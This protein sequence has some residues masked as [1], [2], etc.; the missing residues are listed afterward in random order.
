MPENLGI[1]NVDLQILSILMEN[2]QTPYTEIAKKIFVSGGTIHVRMK[3]L[4]S[5]GVVRGSQVVIDPSKIGY[6]ITAFLGV[7]LEKNSLYDEVA[8]QLR[9]ISEVT[10]LH[11]TTG[12]YAMFI[13]I[14]C[15]DTQHLRD[16]LHDK[17][18]KVSGIQ[19]T[20]TIIS[21]EESINRP[22]KLLAEE[23]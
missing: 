20:E 21:L 7:Y 17:L 14:I 3:K 1:D 16:V 22:I 2:A 11:Y 6:D 18:Q 12:I 5:L 9:A 19:R 10:E 4:T 23:Q 15:R 8:D 13:K